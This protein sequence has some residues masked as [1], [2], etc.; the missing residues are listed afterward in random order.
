MALTKGFVTTAGTTA[1]D[2]RF[3]EQSLVVK[4]TNDVP[5]GGL[6]YGA[7]GPLVAMSNMTLTIPDQVVFAV[8]RG[9]S[10]GVNIVTVSGTYTVTI[11]GAPASNSRIDVI[12]IKHN[13]TSFGDADSNPVIGVVQGDAAASPLP[14]AIPTGAMQIGTIQVPAGA[15]TTSSSGVVLTN[16][17]PGTALVGTPIRY[18]NL[19]AMN[20]DAANV[21]DGSLGYVKG[22]DLYWMRG[23]S[24]SQAT[25]D[26]GWV[27]IAAASGYASSG[28]LAY[29]RLGSVVYLRGQVQPI[30]G[31]VAAATVAVIPSSVAPAQNTAFSAAGSG[32]TYAKLLVNSDGTIATGTPSAT[33][34]YLRFDGIVYPIG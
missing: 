28:S 29:R 19:T 30:S 27:P 3:F 14:K 18:R 17:I 34:P 22:G 11:A 13:D 9:S 10:D 31:N 25:G 24:W 6:L 7:M 15:T 33:T 32:T 20:A 23:G 26:T 5:R 8:T 16:T 1:L 2:A 12:Y 21:I 4:N